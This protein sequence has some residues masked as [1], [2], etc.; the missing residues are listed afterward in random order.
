MSGRLLVVTGTVGQTLPSEPP[1]PAYEYIFVLRGNVVT[2]W[3]PEGPS[4][5]IKAKDARFTSVLAVLH[6]GIRAKFKRPGAILMKLSLGGYDRPALV[7][8]DRCAFLDG[9]DIADLIL[10]VLVVCLV[11]LRT[12][13]GLLKQRV[14]ESTLNTNYDSLL[15]LVGH[16]DALQNA[17]RHIIFP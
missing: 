15:V 17:F 10:I 5:R 13:N 9:N 14:S 6:T 4:V 16:N 2:G 7:L 8:G 1:A 3:F 12:T 11:L